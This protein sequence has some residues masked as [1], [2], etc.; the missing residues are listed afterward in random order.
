MLYTGESIS[1]AEAFRC[2]LVNRVVPRDELMAEAEKLARAIA[3][4][5]P[6]ALQAVKEVVLRGLDLP[7][8]DAIRFEAGFR[9]MVG[10]T[11]D[12]REGPRSLQREAEAAVQGSL[13][14]RSV[15]PS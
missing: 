9:A 8:A 7:L 10:G 15:R 4:G 6:L 3:D 11:E 5:P 12:A 2:G 13:T 1:A 14:L